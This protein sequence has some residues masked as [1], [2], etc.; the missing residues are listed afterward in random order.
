MGNVTCYQRALLSSFMS[1]FLKLED[2]DGIITSKGIW[3][4]FGKYENGIKGQV[5]VKTNLGDNAGQGMVVEFKGESGDGFG[6]ALGISSGITWEFNDITQDKFDII[7]GLVEDCY[8][9]WFNRTA[10]IIVR[11]ILKDSVSGAGLIRSCDLSPESNTRMKIEFEDNAREI[12]V[13]S[14][15]LFLN[16]EQKIEAQ[17][18]LVTDNNVAE[19]IGAITNS[20]I[21][22]EFVDTVSYV[23]L[24]P[25]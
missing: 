9:W 20:D 6:T 21:V 1:G 7:K 18:N 2:S 16:K 8:S 19:I 25:Q 24:Q 17:F 22:Y 4:S 11:N 14:L 12:G 3:G 5:F 15:D 10:D 23:V 13:N